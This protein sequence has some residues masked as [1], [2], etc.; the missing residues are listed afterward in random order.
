MKSLGSSP[1]LHLD[2][3]GKID[4]GSMRSFLATLLVTTLLGGLFASALRADLSYLS[5][6]RITGGALL[7]AALDKGAAVGAKKPL[8]VTYLIKGNRMGVLTKGHTTVISMDNETVYEID[9]AAKTWSS[10]PF[11]QWKQTQETDV[12]EPTAAPNFQVSS[13]SGRTKPVGVLTAR[14]L[15]FT[16]IPAATLT[17]AGAQPVTNIAIDSWIL[18]VPG[19]GELQEFRRKLGAKLG[20][21][22]ALGMSGIAAVK[23]EL[24]PAFEQAAKTIAQADDLPVET[25]IRMG[26]PGSGDLAPNGDVAPPEKGLVSETLSRVGSLAHRKSAG[27]SADE[28]DPS[29]LAELTT[30]LTN[31]GGAVDEAKLNVPGGFKEL[32]PAAPKKEP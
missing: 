11:A 8:V 25:T 30:E 5:T 26:G 18:T 22:Y 1:R 9:F 3:R 15:I 21:V 16:L 19:F 20:Y 12:K 32:K 28:Q 31:L 10:K 13:R 29:I 27:Q 6:T 24:L 2:P 23:P 17:P 14:E 7:K 4:P